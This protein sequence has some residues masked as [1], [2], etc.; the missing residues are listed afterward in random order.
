MHVLSCLIKVIFDKRKYSVKWFNSVSD[1]K[2]FIKKFRW[3]VIP[4]PRYSPE[5]EPSDFRSL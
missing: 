5:L 4:H 3:E 1:L 2:T